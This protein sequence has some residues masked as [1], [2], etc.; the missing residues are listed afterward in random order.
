M[1]DSEMPMSPVI[2]GRTVMATVILWETEVS[3][4]EPS[5]ADSQ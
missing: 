2:V 3:L 4:P 5:L 1:Y